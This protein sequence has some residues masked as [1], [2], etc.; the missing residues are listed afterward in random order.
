MMDSLHLQIA[1]LQEL[2]NPGL[3]S[4]LAKPWFEVFTHPLRLGAVRLAD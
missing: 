2:T 3:G 1:M 4:Y